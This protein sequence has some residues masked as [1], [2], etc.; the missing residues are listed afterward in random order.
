MHTK[1]KNEPDSIRHYTVI[2]QKAGWPE[3]FELIELAQASLLAVLE[4]RSKVQNEFIFLI[5]INYVN[6]FSTKNMLD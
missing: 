3:Q 6:Y 2:Q 5:R 1:F 4:C